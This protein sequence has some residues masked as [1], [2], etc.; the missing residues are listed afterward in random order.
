MITQ[1]IVK[2]FLDYDPDT[3]KLWWRNRARRW[4]SSDKQ[5]KTWNSR[6]GGKE[7]FTALNSSDYYHGH[8]LNKQYKAHRIIWLYITPIS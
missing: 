6:Y 1:E 8:I 7:A 5:F 3:G 2:E 4:F